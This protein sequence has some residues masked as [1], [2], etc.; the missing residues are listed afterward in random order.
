MA[1]IASTDVTYTLVKKIKG[2]DGY[3]KNIMTIAF[4]DGALTYPSGGVPLDA[5]KLGVPY[6][7]VKLDLFGA[8]SANGL[9]YKY[10]AANNKIRIYRSGGFTPAGTVATHTHTIPAGTDGAGGISGTTAPAFTG[11]AAVAASLVELVAATTAPAA[12]TLY[13]EVVG[14]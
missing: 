7:I 6:Q 8:A 9:V 2:D 13:L 14:W 11:T 12:A 1:D 3:T 5:N 10:D 4:G